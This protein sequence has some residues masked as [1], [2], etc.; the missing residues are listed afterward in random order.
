ML[1]FFAIIEVRNTRKPKRQSE[2]T[3]I[4]KTNVMTFILF[5]IV[6]SLKRIILHYYYINNSVATA[7][8][9]DAQFKIKYLTND[10]H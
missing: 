2:S 9:R 8:F 3:A 10:S 4:S 6:I 1:L 7:K 5:V